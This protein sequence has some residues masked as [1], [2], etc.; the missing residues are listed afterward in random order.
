MNFVNGSTAFPAPSL[1]DYLFM[2]PQNAHPKK[3]DPS[4]S[5]ARYSIPHQVEDMLASMVFCQQ[6]EEIVP[7]PM[8]TSRRDGDAKSG[9]TKDGTSVS[10]DFISLESLPIGKNDEKSSTEVG[11]DF[12]SL[13]SLPDPMEKDEPAAAIGSDFIS[14]TCPG[15]QTKPTVPPS[16]RKDSEYTAKPRVKEHGECNYFYVVT[17]PLVD[18]VAMDRPKPPAQQATASDNTSPTHFSALSHATAIDH[19]NTV[20]LHSRFYPRDPNPNSHV[21]QHLDAKAA[22]TKTK[23]QTAINTIA[24][25]KP[26]KTAKGRAKR[27]SPRQDDA[28]NVNRLWL[29]VDADTYQQLGLIGP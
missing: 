16:H 21:Q 26:Q 10:S 29:T 25:T 28:R 15:S 2:Q 24:K 27:I 20:A 7:E 17:G 13:G 19:C 4:S 11:S 23:P 3:S 14:L 5:A 9:K 22:I 8:A 6:I 18:I 12:I 1:W